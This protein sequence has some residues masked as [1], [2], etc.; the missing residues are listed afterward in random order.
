[1]H[2]FLQCCEV[3]G[4]L[5]L[6]EVV[7]EVLVEGILKRSKTCTMTWTACGHEK[8]SLRYSSKSSSRLRVSGAGPF[9]ARDSRTCLSKSP[10]L[11]PSLVCKAPSPESAL[12]LSSPSMSWTSTT[13]S[14]LS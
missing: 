7:V 12:S 9:Q 3:I 5:Q 14:T 1:M 2:I 4:H 6:Q 11:L 10:V 13:P 8:R